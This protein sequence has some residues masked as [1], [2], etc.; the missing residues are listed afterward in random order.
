MGRMETFNWVGSVLGLPDIMYAHGVYNFVFT[1]PT[2]TVACAQRS[3]LTSGLA[4]KVGVEKL[5]RSSKCGP[6]LVEHYRFPKRFPEY[7]G[8]LSVCQAM[9]NGRYPHIQTFLTQI[10]LIREILS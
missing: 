1:A 2:G 5:Y 8:A 4:C 7:R 3:R 10:L 9:V 6:L